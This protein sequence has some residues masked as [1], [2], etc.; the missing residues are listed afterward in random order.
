MARI[1]I[2]PGED[3]EPMQLKQIEQTWTGTHYTYS[4]GTMAY[5]RNGESG[6][7]VYANLTDSGFQPQNAAEYSF[8]VELG[9]YENGTWTTV[10]QSAGIA[11]SEIAGSIAKQT[12]VERW[13]EE[14]YTNWKN[15]PAYSGF[16]FT[17]VV[18]EPNSGMLVLIGISALAL[19]RKKPFSPC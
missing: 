18:P 1:F 7:T 16:S 11:Y 14:Y 17:M 5:V 19:M 13:R 4:E 15:I 9:N 8:Y 2:V 12:T 10:A 3:G 6:D